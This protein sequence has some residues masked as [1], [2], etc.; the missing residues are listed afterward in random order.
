MPRTSFTLSIQT[1]SFQRGWASQR[2]PWKPW[3]SLLPMPLLTLASLLWV[4]AMSTNPMVHIIIPFWFPFRGSLQALY[5]LFDVIGHSWCLGVPC[6]SLW[7]PGPLAFIFFSTTASVVVQQ[8]SSFYLCRSP[9]L[10][11]QAS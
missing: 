3:G 8:P 10:V 1:F 9:G 6:F 5:P 4:D 11:E 2:F 7:L